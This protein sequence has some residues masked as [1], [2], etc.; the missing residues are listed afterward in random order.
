[1]GSAALSPTLSPARSR[2]AV[3]VDDQGAPDLLR[4]PERFVLETSAATLAISTRSRD[5]TDMEHLSLR[6]V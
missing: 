1:M 3:G 2:A 4:P 6:I 5:Q